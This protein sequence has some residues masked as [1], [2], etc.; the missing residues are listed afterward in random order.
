MFSERVSKPKGDHAP[1]RGPAATSMRNLLSLDLGAMAPAG[2]YLALRV[3][4]AF[5]QEEVNALPSAWVDHYT[6]HGYL[7]ADPVLRWSFG[8]EGVCRWSEIR[9]P[10]PRA[11]L[12]AARDHGLVYG[13]A[14]SVRGAPPGGLRSIGAFARSDREYTDEETD[15][16]QAYLRARHDALAPPRNVTRAEIEALRLIKNGH[17][18]KQIAYQLGVTEGA[19]K[20]R[21]K[22][23]RV[24]LEAKTAAEAISRA[25]S[26][27]LI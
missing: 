21:L 4:F 16:L 10:D 14:V 9:L 20:Q 15:L 13:L 1:R 3:G 23:A 7:A 25:T 24:K 19:V 11:V 26:F 12:V 5:P 17:R 18:L 2:H 22:S 8:S 6:R 27:G